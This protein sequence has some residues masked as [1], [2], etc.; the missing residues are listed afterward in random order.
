MITD[1]LAFLDGYLRNEHA[2]RAIDML[3]EERA[4]LLAD[5]RKGDE[6][7]M[8]WFKAASPYATPGSLESGLKVKEEEITRLRNALMD[9]Y[10]A[11][12]KGVFAVPDEHYHLI[13]TA[14]EVLTP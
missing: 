3:A 10:E 8:A 2:R 7:L 12:A 5:V 14:A 13:T 9:L 4:A 11:N 1:P 6:M